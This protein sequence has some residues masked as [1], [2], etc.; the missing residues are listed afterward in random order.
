MIIDVMRFEFR[1]IHFDGNMQTRIDAILRIVGDFALW[2]GDRKVY[3]EVEFCLVEFAVALGD[4]LAVVSDDGPNFV[5]TSV[6]SETEG[7]VRFTLANSG[8]WRISAAYQDSQEEDL[9]RTSELKK[10]A[11]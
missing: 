1:N 11:L 8:N 7:L 9:I 4:W 10:A 3:Q 2:V 6:E 5:Y